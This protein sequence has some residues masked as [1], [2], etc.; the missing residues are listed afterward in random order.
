MINMQHPMKVKKMII[1]EV[2]R[3]PFCITKDNNGLHFHSNFTI[4]KILKMHSVAYKGN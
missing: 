3:V 2:L 1:T 4:T